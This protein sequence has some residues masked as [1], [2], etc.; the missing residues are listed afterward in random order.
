MKKIL[1]IFSGVFILLL[2]CA[3]FVACDNEKPSEQTGEI[4]YASVVKL[5]ETSNTLKQEVTVKSFID[6]D[7][8]HFNVSNSLVEGGVLKARY[9]AINTPESTGK[10]EEYG[11]TASD[12]TKSKLQSAYSIMI[13]SDNEKLNAD[14]TGSRYLVWVWYKPTAD[15][16]YRNLNIEILQNGLAIASNSAQNRYGD[17]CVKAI[18]QAKDLKLNVYSG[19]EDPRY[20]YGTAQE[21]TLKE[22]RLNIEKYDGTKVAFEGVVTKDYSQ[23]VYV[24]EYDEELDLYFGMTVYYGFGADSNV[25]KALKVGNRVRIVGSVQYY[26]NGGTYQVSGLSYRAMKPND[27]ENVQLIEEGHEGAFKETSA[28]TFV[29]GKVTIAGE[30]D[31][32]DSKTYDYAELVM[33]SSI[34]MKNLVVKSIYTTTNEE[35]SSKGAMTITCEVN[36]VTV[37]VRTIVLYEGEGQ[38]RRLVTA[39]KYEGK[40]I[41]VKGIVDYYNGSYQIKVY[42]VND[43]EI[44]E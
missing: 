30:E 42:S 37:D 41:N 13:E 43:I 25:L 17:Y 9:L 14:S 27:P 36:G 20:Y 10:I 32:Q 38:E 35:S 18:Q 19:K 11:K 23:T 40:I 16:S 33:S 6:G 29:N 5:D 12:F 22:L 39:D 7:T 26:A 34:S 3:A 24:E 44:V 8:T 21:L 31:D 28:D 4:D 15:S 2:L 1:R